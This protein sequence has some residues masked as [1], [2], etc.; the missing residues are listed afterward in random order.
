M[1]ACSELTYDGVV[2]VSVVNPFSSPSVG[3]KDPTDPFGMPTFTPP[4]QKQPSMDFS[5]AQVS[6]TVYWPHVQLEYCEKKRKTYG[7]IACMGEGCL[8][9]FDFKLKRR[10]WYFGIK[11]K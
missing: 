3:G 2:V 7:P 9:I 11:R 8:G 5:D 10:T 6:F 1:I 4:A